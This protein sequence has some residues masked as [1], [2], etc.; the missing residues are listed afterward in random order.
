MN[1]K[2]ALLICV[3]ATST[4]ANAEI[5]K[6]AIPT[7]SGFQFLWWPVLPVP[8]GWV[9]DDAASQ[10]KGVNVL[11]PSGSTF[12][13]ASAVIYARADFKPRLPSVHSLIDYIVQDKADFTSESPSAEIFDRPNVRNGD[14][15]T[16]RVV[17]YRLPDKRQWELVAYGEEG[18]FYLLFTVSGSTDAN[19]K[20]AESV[21]YGLLAKYKKRL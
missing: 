8:K 15:Q 4:A 21:F 18:D 3:L 6:L 16:L 9:H 20:N 5:F 1:R 14:G 11:L 10:A 12:D 2:M 13:N 7:D 17:S 19:L